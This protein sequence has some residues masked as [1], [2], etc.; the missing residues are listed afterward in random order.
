MGKF[1]DIKNKRFGRLVALE[2]DKTSK[3]TKW[4]CKCDCGNEKLIQLTHLQSGA[5]TS[6]GCYQKEIAN[7]SNSK[8]NKTHTSLHN[9]WKSMRQRCLNPNNKSY[10]NYGARGISICEEWSD[11][12]NFYNWALNS[13]YEE[14]LELDRIDNNKGY[15]PQNCHW[16]TSLENNHNRRNTSLI[17]GI[18][19]KDFSKKY[20]MELSSVH[21]IYHRLKLKNIEITTQNIL[22]YANQL[23]T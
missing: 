8:H 18:P 20:N 14:N 9:R 15:T 3:R 16:V 1:L 6:C 13:G 2:R 7:K 11:F 21:Y 5:T 23:P 4:L 22:T 12:N 19:L 10:K 17:D